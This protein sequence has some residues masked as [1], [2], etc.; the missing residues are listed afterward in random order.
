MSMSEYE[1]WPLVSLLMSMILRNRLNILGEYEWAG[2]FTCVCEYMWAE[3]EQKFFAHLW[4]VNGGRR[5][6]LNECTHYSLLPADF[7]AEW[8]LLLPEHRI[9]PLSICMRLKIII[10][11][12]PPIHSRCARSEKALHSSRNLEMNIWFDSYCGLEFLPNDGWR[13]RTQYLYPTQVVSWNRIKFTTLGARNGRP[14]PH[15]LKS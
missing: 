6:F 13:R 7:H 14:L 5:K 11:S 3:H 10:I 8:K 9:S 1:S 4:T 15:A 2:V 12:D